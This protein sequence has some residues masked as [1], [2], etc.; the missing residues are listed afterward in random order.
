MERSSIREATLS[1]VQHR[2]TGVFVG[3]GSVWATG[4]IPLPNLQPE[5]V[6]EQN[7]LNIHRYNPKDPKSYYFSTDSELPVTYN[8]ESNSPYPKSP[9]PLKEGEIYP[10]VRHPLPLKYPKE[11]VSMVACGDYHSLFLTAQGAVWACGA[12]H[13]GRLGLGKITKNPSRPMHLE[14]LAQYFFIKVGDTLYIYIYI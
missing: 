7:I 9:R 13:N 12:H 11:R 3:P 10:L 8:F 14:L 6:N 5:S 4:S 1:D 2:R